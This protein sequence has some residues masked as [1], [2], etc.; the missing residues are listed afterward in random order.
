MELL[1]G[2][3]EVHEEGD[4]AHPEG[5]H[6]HKDEPLPHGLL[7]VV[8]GRAHNTDE[9][10]QVGHLQQTSCQLNMIYEREYVSYQDKTLENTRNSF[11]V[12]GVPPQ[13]DLDVG[14]GDRRVGLKFHPPFTSLWKLTRRDQV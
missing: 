7:S 13:I 8:R 11:N 12:A 14:L 6:G 4:Q 5:R 9:S 1:H 3:E 10:Y 2:V